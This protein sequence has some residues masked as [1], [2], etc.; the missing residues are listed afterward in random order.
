MLI[1]GQV[2]EE[3]VDLGT[4]H[5]R[6]VFPMVV[7][8]KPP[9]PVQV[10]LLRFQYAEPSVPPPPTRS[11]PPVGDGD[12]VSGGELLLAVPSHVVR[13]STLWSHPRPT[14]LT[15]GSYP[16]STPLSPVGMFPAHEH[17]LCEASPTQSLGTA[18]S[19]LQWHRGPG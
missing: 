4:T 18:R 19:R 15:M 16:R 9:N 14:A 3:L 7:S 6:R 12:R 17:L 10:D 11:C 2:T 8:D 1:Y 5:I 13:A